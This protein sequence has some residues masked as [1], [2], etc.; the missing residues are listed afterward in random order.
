MVHP[1]EPGATYCPLN[2]VMGGLG[3]MTSTVFM[4]FKRFKVFF[5]NIVKSR[6]QKMDV[7]LLHFCTVLEFRAQ[8]QQ[9]TFENPSLLLLLGK[10]KSLKVFRQLNFVQTVHKR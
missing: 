7:F 4:K 5:Q 3:P 10:P 2:I 9:W 6:I 1:D 8:S